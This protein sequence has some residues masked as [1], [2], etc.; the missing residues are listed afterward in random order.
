MLLTTEVGWVDFRHIPVLGFSYWSDLGGSLFSE[1]DDLKKNF[2]KHLF[3]C[4]HCIRK[5][6]TDI[7]LEGRH[8]EVRCYDA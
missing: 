7:N 1:N 3:P 8:L 5:L 2:F 4:N 6:S